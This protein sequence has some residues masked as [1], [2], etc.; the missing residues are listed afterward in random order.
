MY[1]GECEKWGDYVAE[2]NKQINDNRLELLFPSPAASPITS[3]PSPVSKN[4][5]IT[6]SFAVPITIDSCSYRIKNHMH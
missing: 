2:T 5:F 1:T 4:K 6:K 3:N